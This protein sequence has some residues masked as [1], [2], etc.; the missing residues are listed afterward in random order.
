[1]NAFIGSVVFAAALA[2]LG[3][4][5]GRAAPQGTDGVKNVID[6]LTLGPKKQ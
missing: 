1:M 3:V 6:N 4:T 2:V 5:P